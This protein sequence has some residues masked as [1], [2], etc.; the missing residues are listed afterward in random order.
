MNKILKKM[1]PVGFLLLFSAVPSGMVFADVSMTDNAI[2]Q[3][4]GD[5]KGVMEKL[6]LVLR[7]WSKGPVQVLLPILTVISLFRM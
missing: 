3:Q 2:V 6:L 4:N 1:Q 5:C 7:S